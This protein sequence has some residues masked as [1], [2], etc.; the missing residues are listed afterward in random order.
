MK[1]HIFWT[2]ELL[3]SEITYQLPDKIYYKYVLG[4]IGNSH[5]SFMGE[6]MITTAQLDKKKQEGTVI[7]F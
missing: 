2:E 3:V 6:G 5:N 1:K 4:N 7:L